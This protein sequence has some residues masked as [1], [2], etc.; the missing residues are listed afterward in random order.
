MN[1]SFTEPGRVMGTP[2]YMSPEQARGV[3]VDARS[4]IFS[5]GVGALRDDRGPPAVCVAQTSTDVIISIVQ[6]EPVPTPTLHARG[7][8]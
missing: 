8:A 3:E 4:D 7:P 5:L 2:S 6:Q 1:K